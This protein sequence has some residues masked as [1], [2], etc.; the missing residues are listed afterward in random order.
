MIIY[1][2]WFIY[3]LYPINTTERH[4]E[5]MNRLLQ[6]AMF[7]EYTWQCMRRATG[8]VDDR[9]VQF[10]LVSLT[11][12]W[13]FWLKFKPGKLYLTWDLGH[14]EVSMYAMCTSTFC[15]DYVLFRTCFAIIYYCRVDCSEFGRLLS[16]EKCPEFW[17]N[18]RD[19]FYK[20]VIFPASR[21]TH[22]PNISWTML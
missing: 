10:L 21:C 7:V 4:F 5:R 20:G 12:P 3:S 19:K 17:K 13:L 1:I 15:V 6:Q 2:H 8:P 18:S 11:P 16:S 22:K 14:G 9:L